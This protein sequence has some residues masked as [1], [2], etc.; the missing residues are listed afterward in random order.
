MLDGRPLRTPARAPL[1]LPSAALA[2][3]LAEEWRGQGETIAP[4]ALPLTRL[5]STAQDRM[6]GQRAAAIAEVAG[7]ARTDLLCYR[8][9][10][11]LDLALRQ[12]H[13][14]QP[15]LDWAAATFGA[16]LSVTTA[17]LPVAQPEA[18][19]GRLRAAIEQLGDWPL[20][21]LHAVT[22]ALGS[23]VLGLALARGRIDAA[24]A[25]A[26][27]LLDEL[28]EI[29]RW[30][31]DGETERRHEGLARDVGAAATFLDRL[32]PRGDG[33]PPVTPG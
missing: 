13:G 14:W 6:P 17:L 29:E 7:Y 10:H 1:A 4:H 31:K 8:A 21:G 3:A 30:G 12:Q 18:A 32:G 9:A 5:A 19:V 20:V 33:A 15:L 28:Y 25:L 24:Q 2:E 26:A 11:P 23:L 27:S 22:T 16:R